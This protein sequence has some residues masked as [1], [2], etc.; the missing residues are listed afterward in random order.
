MVGCKW[1]LES[2]MLANWR[3]FSLQLVASDLLT[4]YRYPP[5]KEPECLSELKVTS[6]SKNFTLI[7]PANSSRNWHCFTKVGKCQL[8]IYYFWCTATLWLIL[9]FQY[10]N[11]PKPHSSSSTLCHRFQNEWNKSSKSF[12]MCKWPVMLAN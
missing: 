2:K 6:S 11:F 5:L 9:V 10:D 3:E 4:I 7:T 8:F 1:E 12:H